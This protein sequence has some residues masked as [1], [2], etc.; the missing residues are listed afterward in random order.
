MRF[1]FQKDGPLEMWRNGPGDGEAY[2]VPA[3]SLAETL[4]DPRFLLFMGV[5]IGLNLLIGLGTVSFGEAGQ[6]LA[7]QAHIGGF[8]AGLILFAAFDPVAP[9]SEFDIEPSS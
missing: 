6:E 2:R 1:I 7:W 4:R 9:R 3:A 8:F 5:W